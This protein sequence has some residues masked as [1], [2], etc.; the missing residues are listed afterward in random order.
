M[1]VFI[2]GESGK[3]VYTKES[4]L[5]SYERYED[6]LGI[7][8]IKVIE[9]GVGSRQ[10]GTEWEKFRGRRKP[11]IFRGQKDWQNDKQLLPVGA[12]WGGAIKEGMERLATLTVIFRFSFFP[13]HS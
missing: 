5:S 7:R 6:L 8:P 13:P 10:R 12:G 4:N 2:R 1:C 9:V 3:E 11:G